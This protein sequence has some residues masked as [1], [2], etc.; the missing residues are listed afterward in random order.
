MEG[1]VF[2]FQKLVYITLG[3]NKLSL[4]SNVTEKKLLNITTLEIHFL[5]YSF[6]YA[7]LLWT[8][9]LISG[10][11]PPMQIV[12]TI[13]KVVKEKCSFTCANKIRRASLL[14]LPL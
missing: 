3:R 10:K 2:Y 8:F 12:P 1:F 7:T 14:V 4:V 9:P 6:S 13:M 5:Y 11:T